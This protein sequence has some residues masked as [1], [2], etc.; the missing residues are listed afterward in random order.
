MVYTWKC[1]KCGATVEVQ[2]PVAEIDVRPMG[3]E[4][5]NAG[6]VMSG[7]PCYEEWWE[8]VIS[9]T[10]FVTNGDCWAKDGYTK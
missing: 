5:I 10:S 8:R 9:K 7:C 1:R 3:T 2:R 6:L 4:M